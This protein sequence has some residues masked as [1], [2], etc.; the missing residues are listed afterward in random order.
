MTRETK[1]GLVIGAGI[2]LLIGIVVSDHLSVAQKH[3][4]PPST[5]FVDTSSNV[6]TPPAE[7]RRTTPMSTDGNTTTGTPGGAGTPA[8]PG[9]LADPLAA[10]A[11][12][13]QSTRTDFGTGSGVT[14][15]RGDAARGLP[16]ES[17]GLFDPPPVTG[18]GAVLPPGN[19]ITLP[20]GHGVAE[21]SSVIH[22]VKAGET[23]WDIARKYYSDGNKWTLIATAN[24]DALAKQGAMREGLKLAIPPGNGP[25]NGPGTPGVRPPTDVD[26]TAGKTITVQAG[27]TLS[28]LAARHLGSANRWQELF[29]ANSDQLKSEKQQLKI[30]MVLRLPGA[31]ATAE[32]SH[33][34]TS[35]QPKPAPGTGILSGSGSGTNTYTVQQGDS[36]YTIAKKTLGSVSR[37]QEIKAANKATLG[38]S[39]KLQIGQKLMIPSAPAKANTGLDI[40]TTPPTRTH[41]KTPAAT[42][43]TLTP[44]PVPSVGPT[45]LPTSS[46][47]GTA[48]L[49]DEL[50]ARMEEQP[51]L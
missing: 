13:A 7:M 36:L 43:T 3:D 10:R 23:L 34:L 27:D 45:A 21:V 17:I 16:T 33:N 44:A 47:T 35:D 30:G 18:G 29:K 38:G 46:T 31:K 1:L 19:T 24:K 12:D 11:L 37:W 49:L 6:L 28:K 22:T 5:G 51:K 20:G 25:G 26:T 48:L 14:P 15:G 32:T 39:D 9:G 4:T 50:P 40:T 41:D 8:A 2:I 42:V